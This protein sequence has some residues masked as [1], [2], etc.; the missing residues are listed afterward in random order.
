MTILEDLI[1]QTNSKRI[2]GHIDFTITLAL[3]IETIHELEEKTSNLGEYL[4]KFI[5]ESVRKGML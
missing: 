4:S 3:S 5:E 1:Q 2:N